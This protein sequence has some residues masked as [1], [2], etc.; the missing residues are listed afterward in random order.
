MK[1]RILFLVSLLSHMQ[2]GKEGVKELAANK[3]HLICRC[4]IC[5][6]NGRTD[7]RRLTGLSRKMAKRSNEG[8]GIGLRV[9]V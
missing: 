3:I 5:V 7:N 8:R 2:L 4:D 6:C 9:L 1:T